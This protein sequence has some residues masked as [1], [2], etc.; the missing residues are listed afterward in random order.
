[1]IMNQISENAEAHQVILSRRDVISRALGLACGGALLPGCA[2]PFSSAEAKQPWRIGCYT[3]P[4]DKYEYQVALD[5]I[6]LAGFKYAAL[7]TCKAPRRLVISPSTS[8]AEAQRV[9]EEARQ[10]ELKILSVYGG[11]IAVAKSLAA[12]I[13]DL[14]R[15]IDN[16]A[17]CGSESLLMGGTGDQKT[18]AAYYQAIAEC[19][20]YAADLG[21]GITIKPHGGLNAT[22]PQCRQIVQDVN[23]KNFRIWYDAGNILYYSNGELDPVKDAPSVDGLVVGMC[24]KDYRHPKNV[25]V[26]PGS[27][28]VDFPAV[29]ARLQEGGF[30]GGP[31]VVECLQGG[32]LEQLQHQARQTREFLEDLTGQASPAQAQSDSRP[33]RV[34]VATIDITP[35]IGYRMSGYFR[36]RLCTGIDN[37]LQAKALVLQQDATQTA[38]V[39][40]DL[41]GLNAEI[42][43]AAREQITQATGIP[44]NNILIAATHSHTGPLYYGALRDHFHAKAQAQYG[45]DPQ[46]KVDYP[47]QLIKRIAQVVKQAQ[48]TC[49][50]V[51]VEAGVVPQ[52]GLS[53]NRRFFMKNGPVRF[54]P[55]VLNPN[56]IK[57]AGPID[58]DLGILLFREPEGG[59]VRAGLV[60]FA[61][62]LD[63]VG[64]TR[65]AADYPYYLEQCLRQTWGQDFVLLFGTGCCGDLNHIDVTRKERLKTDFI[66]QT[67]GKTVTRK[68]ESLTPIKQPE[69]GTRQQKLS[70]PLQSYTQ[71][72]LKQAQA[73][74]LQMNT[75]Q[76]SFMQKVKAY[77]TLSL[78]KYQADSIDLEVQVFRIS[79][80]LAVVGLPGEV[81]VDLGLAIKQASPF[82]TTL[83]IQLCQDAPGYIPTQ[84][85]F[86]EGSYETVNS[87]VA[88][89]SG[90]A[91]VKAVTQLLTELGSA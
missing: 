57:A 46:E 60:N 1:M 55:G 64:G 49:S 52:K 23:H 26:T 11:G 74:V 48:Q 51:Q 89:G 86:K 65:Y 28:Q 20:D 66:G 59:P 4:W 14:K 6:A 16:C 58:P 45:E 9:G 34:G 43:Q 40:C 29:M 18:F 27:G 19:C 75:T 33:L 69:L 90:E 50:P 61:L 63:T 22:G 91:M 24:I 5:Q 3:R 53:F 38:W 44:V 78:A 77:K 35:P 21:V 36:E 54:N 68:A 12:G 79:D 70:V 7:M 41:I 37:P 47:S 62:H 73:D 80:Q 81:F 88:P 39:F 87:R 83:V 13:D 82:A 84:K 2:G 85:A 17:A 10:R 25:A 8:I 72:Q 56:I 15:L 42:S 67:L 31:L 71:T 32:S 76:L 30:R